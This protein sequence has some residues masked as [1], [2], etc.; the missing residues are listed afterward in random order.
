MRTT[1]MPSP[2]GSEGP[3]VIALEG[4]LDLASGAELARAVASAPPRP[5]RVVLDV[6]GLTFVDA[7]GL[8]ALLRVEQELRAAGRELAV[9]GR[10]PALRRLLHLADAEDLFP[11][12]SP[13]G[14]AG[15]RSGRR[16]WPT[17]S[18]SS[19]PTARRP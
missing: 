3:I 18:S 1:V 8:R 2:T 10:S 11:P 7:A 9:R 4:E 12:E 13:P 6:A 15:C 19:T 17:R 5:R 16:R 14:P